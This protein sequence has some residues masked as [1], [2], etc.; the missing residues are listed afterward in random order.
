MKLLFQFES[1]SELC[2]A[3]KAEADLYCLEVIP[4]SYYLKDQK[5]DDIVLVSPTRPSYWR[6]AFQIVAGIE[7]SISD[8]V[9]SNM[10]RIED[11]WRKV[12]FFSLIPNLND[13]DVNL[14][15]C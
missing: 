14:L 10:H 13:I 7:D 1:I 6:D 9:E 5:D 4:E 3:A 12:S 11:Y 15:F 2:D 8:Q